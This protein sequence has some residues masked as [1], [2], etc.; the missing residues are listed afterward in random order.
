MGGSPKFAAPFRRRRPPPAATAPS[1]PPFPVIKSLG[2]YL[3]GVRGIAGATHLGD[4]E[5]IL[6]LDVG[7]LMEDLLAADGALS[8]SD[9]GGRAEHERGTGAGG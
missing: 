6:V 7:S 1:T 8:L 2:A 3:Q 5:T 9:R 4:H